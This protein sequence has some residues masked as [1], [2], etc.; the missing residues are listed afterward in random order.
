MRP[1]GHIDLICKHCSRPFTVV[2]SKAKVYA[3]RGITAKFCS[4]KCYNNSRRIVPPT[5]ECEQCKETFVLPKVKSGSYLRKQRFCSKS[6]AN[7]AQRTGC[8][9]RH[10]YRLVAGVPEHRLVME[11]S[12][13]RP[14]FPME[15]VHHKNGKRADNRIEN[16]ELWSSRHGRGQRVEDR[17]R[18]AVSFLREHGFGIQQFTE[19]EAL[20]GLSGI[21]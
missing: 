12:I 6:C 4:K 11:R 17:I 13:G 2:G 8:V 10:G 5:K 15:T 18:D 19:S 16:L 21:C 7:A 14:L 9:D 3:C 20:C 1:L